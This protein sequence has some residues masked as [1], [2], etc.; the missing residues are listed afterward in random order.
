ANPRA[1]DDPRR[2]AAITDYLLRIQRAYAWANRNYL[3]Y[4]KAQSAETRVPVGDL[5]ELFNGRSNDYALGPVT[6]AI[7]RSHQ[8]VADTFQ[9]LGV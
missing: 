6:S 1:I 4:A 2:H 5:V 9:R 8:E 7:V 3:A